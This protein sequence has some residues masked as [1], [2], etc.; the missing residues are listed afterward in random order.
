MRQADT[1]DGGPIRLRRA[2]AQD[3]VAARRALGPD[4]LVV[5]VDE[6]GRG[7]LAG[8]V[9]AAAVVLGAAPAVDGLD[10]SK[11]LT[12][13]RREKIAGELRAARLPIALGHATAAEID[14]LNILGASLLAMQRAVLALR[15]EPALV[16]VDGRHLPELPWPSLA[17]VRG[18]SQVAEIA[19]ASIIAKVTRDAQMD[20]LHER[21]PAYGFDRHRGY[22]TAAHLAALREY[23]PTPEHRRSFAPVRTLLEV[24]TP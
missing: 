2:P 3:W 5:G 6:V 17:V 16:L 24:S 8:D 15:L 18:D 13:R 19:A 11:K 22:P 12:A 4:A 9:V 1:D 21:W 14:A 10:D 23:G 20:R 7:P